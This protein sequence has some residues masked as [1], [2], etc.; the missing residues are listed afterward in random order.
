MSRKPYMINNRNRITNITTTNTQTKIYTNNTSII[1][2][3]GPTGPAGPMGPVGH[4]GNIG[5]M[6]PT[7]PA[8]NINIPT[9]IR[10]KL[11]NATSQIVFKINNVTYIGSGFYYYDNND[12]LKCGYFITAA[13][14]II[15]L[16]DGVIHKI[17]GAYIQNPI[18]TK[19]TSINVANIFIDGIA[20]VALIKTGIDLSNYSQFCLQINN[21]IVNAGDLCYVVGNP[22]GIDEDSISVGCVRDP[23]YCEP[24]GDQ[25]TDSILVSAPGMGGNSGGPIVNI[26]GNVIGIYTFGQTGTECFGGGSNQYVLKSTLSI[27]KAGNDN[28]IKLYLG[29]NWNIIN[30]TFQLNRYYP[31]QTSFDTS[32]VILSGINIHSP[33]Y[34]ISKL[35]VNSLLLQCDILNADNSI[36]KTIQFGNK[37]NQRTP[38]VLLYYPFNT[39]VKI[40]YKN[41][42]DNTIYNQIVTLN[43]LYKDVAESS[44]V[45]LATGYREK[46]NRYNTNKCRIYE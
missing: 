24:D 37:N 34:G 40:Y 46:I 10:L 7:G 16:I 28:K 33:F 23:N 21:D 20:D 30:S 2:Q 5:P 31:S 18:N 4:T 8:G 44:D 38:G 35:T 14:C 27:L 42:D 3:L 15:E 29:L 12:D 11:Q 39:K 9:N 22:G 32:G 36:I 25:I 17:S 6:G 43:I 13:H 45:P 19:W 41:I 26:K 1:G